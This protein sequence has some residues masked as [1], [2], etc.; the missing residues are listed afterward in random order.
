MVTCRRKPL[1]LLWIADKAEA[2]SAATIAGSADAATRSPRGTHDVA[3]AP[4]AKHTGRSLAYKSA[5]WVVYL[6]FNRYII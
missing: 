5:I 6:I 4:A 1:A 3:T 2:Q